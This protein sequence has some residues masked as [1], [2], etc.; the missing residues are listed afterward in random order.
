MTTFHG[1]SGKSAL[2]RVVVAHTVVVAAL[3][4]KK[5]IEI[6]DV[7]SSVILS[8]CVFKI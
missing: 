4:S 5:S 6:F 8:D 3:R 2:A 1:R 7:S